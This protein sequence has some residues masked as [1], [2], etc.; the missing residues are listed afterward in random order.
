MSLVD[1][2][3]LGNATAAQ[4]AQG[5]GTDVGTYDLDFVRKFARTCRTI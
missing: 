5:L 1:S 2:A 3:E 4:V